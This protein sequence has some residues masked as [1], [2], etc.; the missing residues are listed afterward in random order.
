MNYNS[1]GGGFGRRSNSNSGGGRSFGGG[2]SGFS[3]GRGGRGGGRGGRRGQ[4]LDISLY[5]QTIN[6]A[7]LTIVEEQKD[8]GS[9]ESL[10]LAPEI[11]ESL[12]AR[13]YYSPTEIQAL[14]IPVVLGGKDIVAISQTGSGKTGAFL[15][16]LLNQTIAHAK[17]NQI[18]VNLIIAPTRELAL[19][20]E[21]ELM[22][23]DLRKL[24][25]GVQTCIGGASMGTQIRGLSRPNHFIIGTPGRL[26][27]LF[28]RGVLQLEY[29][30]AVVLDEMDR[31]LDM[32][33]SDDINLLFSKIPEVHQN[34]F[35]SATLDKKVQP[36]INR[37]AP[38]ADYIQLNQPKPSMFVHQE[39]VHIDRSNRKIDVL[40]DI[41]QKEGR[42]K[43]LV[44]VNTQ[45]MA[46]QVSS[47]LGQSGYITDFIHGG[48]TQKHREIALK[49]F[50]QTQIDILVATDV[51]ARGIDV[52]D[53]SSV[54]NFDEPM[55]Y[56]DYIHRIG[57]TGRNG[58]FGKAF[59][60]I[61]R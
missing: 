54:V 24:R 5:N 58:K 35:F 43:T 20:I 55:S 29:V 56:E 19:Q 32:G 49:R 42:T 14:S 30:D 13:G 47:Q 38:T 2:R 28:H 48:K 3:S 34:L 7:E 41:L 37:L 52:S 21:K 23:F 51:A 12:T 44:F 61:S 39:A 31:M 46:E 25:I 22:T 36:T 60:L 15:I 11:L 8:F 53:I 59:T 50:R 40:L 26:V 27:D 57:R 33:F 1:Q 6:Q 17:N 45:I 10:N 9:F 4:T 16:P 18:Q